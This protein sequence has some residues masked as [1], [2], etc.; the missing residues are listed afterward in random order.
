M[1]KEVERGGLSFYEVDRFL[2]N[3]NYDS[4]MTE[5]KQKKIISYNNILTTKEFYKYTYLVHR[6]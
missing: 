6:F 4:I 2:S 5:L 3:I 1:A